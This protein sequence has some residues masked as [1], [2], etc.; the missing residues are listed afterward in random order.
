MLVKVKRLLIGCLIQVLVFVE[1][2]EVEVR[3]Q[4][5]IENVL[6]PG[7]TVVEPRRDGCTL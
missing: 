2:V 5:E 1:Q 7:R 6:E 4:V 3:G